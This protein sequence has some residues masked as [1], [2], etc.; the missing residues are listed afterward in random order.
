M[1]WKT[2]QRVFIIRQN[3]SESA[4]RHASMYRTRCT[5]CSLSVYDTPPSYLTTKSTRNLSNMHI[6]DGSIPHNS[7][8]FWPQGQYMLR[9]CHRDIAW[10]QYVPSLVLIAQVVFLLEHRHTLHT[11]TDTRTTILWPSWI[12]PGLPGWAGSRKV[13]PGR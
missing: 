3:R 11:D 12:C 9:F 5:I 4:L 13:K 2:C 1:C 10:I 6:H 7:V 8:S